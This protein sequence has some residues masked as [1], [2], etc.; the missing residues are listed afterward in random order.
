MGDNYDVKVYTNWTLCVPAAVF[1]ALV[2]ITLI[3]WFVIDRCVKYYEHYIDLLLF[4][5]K[6]VFR[7]ALKREKDP[8][9]ILLHGYEIDKKHMV[10]F[11]S[12]TSTV[13]FAVFVSFWAT[14]LVEQTFVCNPELDCFF[15]ESSSYTFLSPP[16]A[17]S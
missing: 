16:T 7:D 9:R 13:I 8:H 6:T 17:T 5:S 14:F 10:W 3:D 4:Y 15:T 12:T 1:F 2:I 11:T